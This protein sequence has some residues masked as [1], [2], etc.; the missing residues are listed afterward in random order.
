MSGGKI[1]RKKQLQNALYH[2]FLDSTY[3]IFIVKKSPDARY[4]KIIKSLP[5]I[6]GV[7]TNKTKAKTNVAHYIPTIG[8]PISDKT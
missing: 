2:L 5:D 1:H 4:E 6:L 8:P 3:S 7:Q